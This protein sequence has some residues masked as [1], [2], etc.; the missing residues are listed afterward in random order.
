MSG[1][2]LLPDVPVEAWPAISIYLP[3]ER[4]APPAQAGA[5]R[6]RNALRA[7]EERL[8]QRGFSPDEVARLLRAASR[9]VDDVDFWQHQ[10]E[11]LAIFIGPDLFRVRRVPFKVPELTIAG[12]F[13]HIR[14]LLSLAMDVPR[15]FILALS[16]REHALYDCTR[17]Q[18]NEVALPDLP[19]G[20]R[21]IGKETEF[22]RTRRYSAPRR[23]AKPRRSFV[24]VSHGLESPA[25]IR[26]AELIEYLRRV[27]SAVTARLKPA[28]AP[29]ILA[30]EAEILGQYRALSSYA[31]LRDEAVRLNP[32]AVD[33][34]EL[35]RQGYQLLATELKQ[36]SVGAKEQILARLG[37][38]DR[39]ATSQLTEILPAA[40][41]GRVA[42]L[43]LAAEA[44]AWGRF[45]PEAGVVRTHGPPTPE[46]EDLLNRA[47]AITL[48]KGGEVYVLPDAEMPQ[49][50]MAAAALRY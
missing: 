13:F 19:G 12:R 30:C 25:E 10:E 27:E 8:K 38:G 49:S 36:A 14:P 4:D 32:F 26:K 40:E 28:G 17:D 29:L 45:I 37:S 35:H 48:R 9:L 5:T 24:P 11:G 3:T 33:R 6:L 34:A 1:T 39:R 31:L 16:A 43:L 7:A 20:V 15:F 47:A 41:S 22:E 50:A 21:A 18:C 42:T 46:D 23:S 44:E 2:T